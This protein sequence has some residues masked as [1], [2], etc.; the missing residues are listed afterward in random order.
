MNQWNRE[1]AGMRCLYCY[2]ELSKGEVDFHSSCS[3]KMFGKAIAPEFD[4]SQDDMLK[5]AEQFIKSQKSVTGV[6]AKLSLGIENIKGKDI[7]DR[8]T[9][10]GLW[11]DYILKPQSDLYP[12]LPENEDL[13]MNLAGFAGIDTVKHSLI[14]L[15]SGELAYITK[16][17]DRYSGGKLHMEDMCQLTDRLTEQKYKGSYEQVAKVILKH[18]V[19]PLLDAINFYEQVVFSFLTGNADM[20]LK[21]FSLLQGTDQSYRLCPAYDLVSSEL[22]VEGDDEE[23]AL[24]LNGKKKKLKRQDF[25]IAMARAGIDGK[26]IQNIFEKFR[27]LVPGWHEYIDISFLPDELKLS[28]HG[29]LEAKTAHVG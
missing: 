24:N 26:A 4:Y 6:Q 23:L 29:I 25:E 9:I 17:E 19:N 11:G 28:Y 10:V 3:K 27:K 20:H 16:R 13:T 15:K 21:N 2:K 8:L 22:V 12:A 14:R 7:P 1:M 18:S 5:L